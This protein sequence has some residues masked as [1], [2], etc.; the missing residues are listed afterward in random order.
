MLRAATLHPTRFLAAACPCMLLAAGAREQD[1]RLG[2]VTFPTSARSPEAQEH[3]RRGAAALHSFWYPVA[4]EEFR[5]ATRIEPDF[6]MARW[7]EAMAHNHPVW[8]DP[9]ETDAA[10]QILA[11]I[12]AAPAASHRGSRAI[13]TRSG[14]STDPARSP[15]ATAPTPR[16][17]S[18]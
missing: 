3:V 10:R 6:A 11:G 18:G 12:P 17:W 15:S 1:L 7:G 16:P 8:G 14:R 2:T 9:Q 13:S 4:L 5:A